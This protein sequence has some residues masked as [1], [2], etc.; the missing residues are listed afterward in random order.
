MPNLF[1]MKKE[2]AEALNAA[3]AILARAETEK[4]SLTTAEDAIV[5]EHLA[6]VKQLNTKIKPIEETN[7]IRQLFPDGQVITGGT[8]TD[9]GNRECWK[10]DRGRLVP[11]LKNNQSFASAVQTGPAPNFGFGDF[12]KAMV[13]PSGNPEI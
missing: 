8:R 2:R 6:T 13:I 12:V 1:D 5:A 9:P 10:D 3:E 7:T 11:V 4:R